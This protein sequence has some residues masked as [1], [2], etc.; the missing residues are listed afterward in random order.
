MPSRR[1]P[2]GAV[3]VVQRSRHAVTTRRWHHARVTARPGPD[4]L[5]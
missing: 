2:I 4:C 3:K 1:A 5:L